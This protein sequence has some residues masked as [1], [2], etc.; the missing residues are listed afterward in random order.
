MSFRE[1]ICAAKYIH[2]ILIEQTG[3]EE[4]K[5]VI[6]N[7]LDECERCRKITHSN[8]VE[9]YG[10]YCPSDYSCKFQGI[11]AHIP[12]MIMELMDKSLNTFIMENKPTEIGLD[13]KYSI[14]SDVATGL[15]YLHQLD[16]PMIHRDITPTNI[17]L[18]PHPSKGNKYWIAKI[19]DLGVAK[20]LGCVDTD[21][22]LKYTRAPGCCAFM[23]PEALV[24]EPYYT[25][26]LDVFSFGG[27]VL[28]MAT[29]EWLSLKSIPTG[30]TSSFSEVERRR[31]Y[32]DGMI[33]EMQKLRPLVE[34]CLSNEPR[35]RPKMENIL[36]K[37]G[38]DSYM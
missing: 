31:E 35:K 34:D 7:F 17:L 24:E 22:K 10:V 23:P 6:E 25:T 9:F 27:V 20:V 36:A 32:L 1:S 14:L 30:S 4:R 16:P 15:K 26:S 2:S 12:V 38:I 28:F 33:E 21:S 19:A 11:Q 29:H 18:N 37:V 8:F 3:Q 13:V 5:R